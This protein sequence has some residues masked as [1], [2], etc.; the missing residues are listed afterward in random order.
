MQKQQRTKQFLAGALSTLMEKDTIENISVQQI[1]DECGVHRK[2][3]YYHFDSKYQLLDWAFYSRCIRPILDAP[4]PDLKTALARV[5]H[6]IDEKRAA[7]TNAFR[8]PPET[9][10][11]NTFSNSF[12]DYFIE[13]MKHLLRLYVK[14]VFPKNGRHTDAL[15]FEEYYFDT[16]AGSLMGNMQ[17]WLLEHPELSADAYMELLDAAVLRNTALP[18]P[19]GE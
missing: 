14:P 8:M 12:Q 17:Q 1:C 3:F 10:F 11:G 13:Q 7:Y 19:G 15:D 2:T 4:S 9:S 16:L 18:L 5:A 6:R